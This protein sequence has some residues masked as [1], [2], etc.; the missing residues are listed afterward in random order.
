MKAEEAKRV[1]VETWASY[2][3]ARKTMLSDLNALLDEHYY[4]KEFVEWW[5]KTLIETHGQ[6]GS[7][8]IPK[9]IGGLIT[10]DEIYNYWKENA[11]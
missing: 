5:G 8:K 3:D 2:K 6:Y 11:K 1:F 10:L 4:P 7:I 9:E